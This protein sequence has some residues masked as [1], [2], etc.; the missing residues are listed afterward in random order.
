MNF[1][2]TRLHLVI[3]LMVMAGPLYFIINHGYNY[4]F[5]QGM[6]AVPKSA[7]T[8]LLLPCNHSDPR[9][10]CKRAKSLYNASF[11]LSDIDR[12]AY[13][14]YVSSRCASNI[15]TSRPKFLIII[16]YRNRIGDLLAFLIYILPYFRYQGVQMDVLI[17]EQKGNAPFNRAKLFNAAIAEIDKANNS[18]QGNG[19]LDRLAGINCF[20]LHDVDKLPDNADVPYYCPSDPQQLMRYRQFDGGS[21]A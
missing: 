18:S 7:D 12:I 5:S 21:Y 6:E 4:I 19:H 2:L 9:A 17:A 11:S 14:E 8:K 15:D 10:T 20:S 1:S 16:P 3:C 13:E